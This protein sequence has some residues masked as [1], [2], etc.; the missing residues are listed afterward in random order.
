MKETR[1]HGDDEGGVD[2]VEMVD[3]FWGAVRL[4]LRGRLGETWI[5]ETE[6][7]VP[8]SCY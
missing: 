8:G 4:G 7:A 1:S 5:P 3:T 6:G 2:E